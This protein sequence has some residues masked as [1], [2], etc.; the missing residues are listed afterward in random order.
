MQHAGSP[1]STAH[2]ALA[3]GLDA[4]HAGRGADAL[5]AFQAVIQADAADSAT[6]LGVAYAH[7]L[8][9]Q[10]REAL[11]S[12][13]KALLLEPRS[14][15]ALMLKADIFDRQGNGPAAASFYQ[16]SVRSVEDPQALPVS[17]AREHARARERVEHYQGRFEA[18]LE[19]VVDAARHEGGEEGSRFAASVDILLGRR[20]VYLQKPRQY[21]FPGLPSIPF[22]PREIFPWLATLEAAT[23]EIRKEALALLQD[24]AA[25]RPY[26]AHDPSRPVLNRGSLYGSRDWGACYLVKNGEP[27]L[28]NQQRC[29]RTMEALRNV[30]LV[31]VPG[32]SPSVL[33]SRLRP[34]TRIPAHHGFVNT[35]LIG[36]LPLVIPG[37]C[38]FRVGPETRSWKEGQAWV[39]DD[40]IEHEA[41]NDGDEERL[42]LIFEVWQPALTAAERR[43]VSMLFEALDAQ[44]GVQAEDTL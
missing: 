12:A 16:A 43:C 37:G 31:H 35:R 21:Y 1:R 36:H 38:G 22:Y 32:R 20:Q 18:A 39:F 6:W 41:W 23:A 17:L 30:P 10:Q 8:L 15:R 33:F 3:Q 19:A 29:P 27:Q 25:Y 42:I 13:D 4:L 24:D 5:A 34:R 40:T 7:L 44:G 26:L 11:E 9:N 2:P 28:H 14:L